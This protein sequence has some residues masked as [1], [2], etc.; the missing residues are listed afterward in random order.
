ML[1]FVIKDKDLPFKNLDYIFI[2]EIKSA[3]ENVQENI[4]AFVV[5]Q[6]ELKEFSLS[7]GQLTQNERQIILDGCLI[8]YNRP[9]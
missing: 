1:P 5:H 9:K 6:N 8:N 4:K 2:P 7:L 3:I